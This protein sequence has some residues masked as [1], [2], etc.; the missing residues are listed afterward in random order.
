[1]LLIEMMDVM[2]RLGGFKIVALK[3]QDASVVSERER[4]KSIMSV[5]LL[6]VLAV[7]P[8]FF[9]SD[10][11]FFLLLLLF[12]RITVFHMPLS[13]SLLHLAD[14]GVQAP[15]LQSFHPETRLTSLFLFWLELSIDL[16]ALSGVC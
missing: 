4:R 13:V 15:T 11:C 2:K 14:Q 6:K 10:V 5:D 12:C 9:L 7:K 3:S 8:T 16:M 1:M